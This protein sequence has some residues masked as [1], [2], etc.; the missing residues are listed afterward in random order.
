MYWVLCLVDVFIDACLKLED[1]VVVFILKGGFS[2]VLHWFQGVSPSHLG[3]ATKH[4]WE[5]PVS[6]SAVAGKTL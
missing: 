3:E 1:N 4:P 6:Q 2:F 5:V